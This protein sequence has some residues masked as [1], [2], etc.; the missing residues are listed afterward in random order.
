MIDQHAERHRR[1]RAA[2]RQARADEAEHLADLARAAPRPSASRRAACGWHPYARPEAN[3]TSAV[4]TPDSDSAFTATIS[5]AD[6]DRQTDG[7]NQHMGFER[8]ANQP[9]TS[10]PT[11]EPA[12]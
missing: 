1:D 7:E 6:S 2:Q 5:T 4:T 9:P 11:V 12:M 3:I 8:S 10:T